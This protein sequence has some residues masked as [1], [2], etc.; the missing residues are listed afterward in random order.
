MRR[1]GLRNVVALGFVSM[2][3]DVSNGMIFGLLWDSL[4]LLFVFT[5]SIVFSLAGIGAIFLFIARK[6]SSVRF[7]KPSADFKWVAPF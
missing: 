7:Y 6:C 1:P 4:G 5:F 2:L 3:N